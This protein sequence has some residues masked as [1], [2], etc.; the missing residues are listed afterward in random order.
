MIVNIVDRRKRQ[1]RF[2]KVNAV[3][4]AAWHDNSC[5]DSDQVDKGS[6]LGTGPDYDKR[7]H[8][9]LAA[10]IR[11]ANDFAD[12]VTL[13][14][15]DQGAGIYEITAME[16]TISDPEALNEYFKEDSSDVP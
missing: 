2:M 1:Y 11:W 15:Y 16:T 6:E 7:E 9:S 10:A 12:P 5:V 4:E 13:Y 14:I 8:I 3:V